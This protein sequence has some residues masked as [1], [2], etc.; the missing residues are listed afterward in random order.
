MMNKGKIILMS[1]SGFEL[2]TS[3][4]VGKR[5]PHLAT[6][7]LGFPRAKFSYIITYSRLKCTQTPFFPS[8]ATHSHFDQSWR[9]SKQRFV[10]CYAHTKRL[11]R[12]SKIYRCSKL[13]ISLECRPFSHSD[14]QWHR[15]E[16]RV[17]KNK[18][19]V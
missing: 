7:T 14:K 8:S 18:A 6:Y 13:R 10:G 1:T 17:D 11:F 9:R 16:V 19:N 5:S 12:L 15:V 2:A 4:S 3:R